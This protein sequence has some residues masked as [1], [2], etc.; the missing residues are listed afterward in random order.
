[1][2]GT[3]I[4]VMASIGATD[5]YKNRMYLLSTNSWGELHNF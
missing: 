5:V 3:I 1:M 2:L 4:I